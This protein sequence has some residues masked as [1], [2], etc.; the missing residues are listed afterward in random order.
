MRPSDRKCHLKYVQLEIHVAD[1][2]DVVDPAFAIGLR[3]ALCRTTIT[4]L[5]MLLFVVAMS[6]KLIAHLDR[7]HASENFRDIESRFATFQNF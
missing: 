7:N 4:E 2:V 6:R 1:L 3:Q 5:L